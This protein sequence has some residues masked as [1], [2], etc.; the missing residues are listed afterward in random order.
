MLCNVCGKNEASIHLTEIVNSQMLELHL[1]DACAHEKE[2]EAK[3][4]F[5]F[6]DLLTG[7]ADFN[8]VAGG[9]KRQTLKC[10]ACGIN[11]EEFG[12]TGR[13]GCA[14]CYQH[15]FKALLPLIKRVQKGTQHVGKKP[16]KM[17]PDHRVH[18]DLRELR[19]RLKKSIQLEE[20]E[21]AARLRDQIKQLETKMKKGSRKADETS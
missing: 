20:F 12:R 17:Q 14:E 5:S 6:N 2:G 21:E 15:F 1:C 11:F 13:L 9:E 7:L 19:E 3:T 18:L 16:A 4:Q 8:S 10:Q